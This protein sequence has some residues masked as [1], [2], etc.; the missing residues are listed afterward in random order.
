MKLT[1]IVDSENRVT[2]PGEGEYILIYEVNGDAVGLIGK[3]PNPALQAE[4]H[5]GLYAL[6][7]VKELGA[8]SLIVSEI[9]R[10]GFNLAKSLNLKVYIVPEGVSADDAVKMVISGKVNVANAPTHEHGHHEHGLEFR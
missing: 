2:G 6:R 10:P 4:M 8:D 1:V 7:R 9:G 3:E 5:R